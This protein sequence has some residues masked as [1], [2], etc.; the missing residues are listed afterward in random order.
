METLSIPISKILSMKYNI[1]ILVALLCAS[2]KGYA[3]ST[4]ELKKEQ[5]GIRVYTAAVA[6]SNIKAIKVEC[7][8][9]A[10]LSQLTAFLLDAKAHEQWV[11][12]TKQSYL[13]KNIGP[14]NLIYYSEMEMP[15]PM[16]NRDAIVN[17]KISQ[18]TATKA[19][20]VKAVAL[21][22]HIPEGKDK[23]RV[24]SSDVSWTV[25]PLGNNSLSIEYIA[26]VDPGG[27]LPA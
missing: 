17:L 23:V 10:T 5:D 20:T 27:A 22:G 25:K 14:G 9:Q 26:Q 19:L 13:V 11:Y 16:A 1:V 12:K 15:W 24:L 3:R 4:W 7:K 18:N 8:V 6:N 21:A 2:L